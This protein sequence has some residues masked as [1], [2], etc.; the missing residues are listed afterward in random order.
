MLSKFVYIHFVCS[1]I[2]KFIGLFDLPVVQAEAQRASYLSTLNLLMAPRLNGLDWPL[3]PLQVLTS[4]CHDLLLL[5]MSSPPVIS[6][7]LPGSFLGFLFFFCGRVL[8]LPRSGIDMAHQYHFGTFGWPSGLDIGLERRVYYMLRP[9]RPAL[10][11]RTNLVGTYHWVFCLFFSL[12]SYVFAAR[13]V[14]IAF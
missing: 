13:Y 2:Q 11:R 5:A 7:R 4:W 8:W 14:H 6:K 3:H 9:Y 12:S 10:G 1:R